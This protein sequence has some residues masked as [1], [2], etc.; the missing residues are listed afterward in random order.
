[1]SICNPQVSCSLNF[2]SLFIAMI[3]NSSVN[4]KLIISPLDK[5][6]PSKSQFSDIRVL[7]ENLSNS[8]CHFPSHKSVL[9]QIFHHS[10]VS[11]KINH[12]HFLSSNITYF[13]Q[14]EPFKVQV[15]ETF[16]CSGPN[17]SNFTCQVWNDK[18][19]PIKHFA[20]IFTVITHNSCESLKLIFY[21]G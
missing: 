7:F 2:A 5:R 11:W 14:K 19:V 16:E 6:I 4:L 8:S 9:L 18:S 17:S 12:Q 15:L 10:L 20:S 21:F 1:M 3:H 13:V